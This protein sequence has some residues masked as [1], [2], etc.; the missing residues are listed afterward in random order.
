MHISHVIAVICLALSIVGCSGKSSTLEEGLAY[1]IS[2]TEAL[3]IAEDTIAHHVPVGYTLPTEGLTASGY[4]RVLIDTHTFSVSAIPTDG[5]GI[6]GFEVSHHGTLFH[7]PAKAD[8]I[9]T[10]VKRRADDR[11]E[12]VRLE[13]E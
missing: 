13:E 7:G 8:A 12:P 6:Y 9:Y 3:R 2:R 4:K 1:R 11:G 10:D 5:Y